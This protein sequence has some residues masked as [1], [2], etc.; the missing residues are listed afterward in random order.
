[1]EHLGIIRCPIVSNSVRRVAGIQSVEKWTLNK[2]LYTTKKT[3]SIDF[4]D[5]LLSSKAT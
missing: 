1:M 5:T 4:P 2:T 3:T